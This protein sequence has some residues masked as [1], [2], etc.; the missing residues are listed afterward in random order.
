MTSL[1]EDTNTGKGFKTIDIPDLNTYDYFKKNK[2]LFNHQSM[3][4][5]TYSFSI[6]NHIQELES[7]DPN[8]SNE[9]SKNKESSLIDTVLLFSEQALAEDWERPEEDEAWNNL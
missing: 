7:F 6:L 1:V 3:I 2:E 8:F 4:H 5:T 9:N